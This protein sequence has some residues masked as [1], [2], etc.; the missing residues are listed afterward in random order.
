M[1]LTRD[2]DPD[3]W[4]DNYSDELYRYALSRVSDKGFAEDI[5]QDTFL[6]AW[7]S[8]ETYAENASEKNWLYAICKNKIIDH[9]RKVSGNAIHLSSAEED[10]YFDESEHWRAN[11]SPK[12]WPVDYH[13]YI[14]TKEFYTVLEGCRKKL[15]SVQQSVF[16]MKFMEEL[17]PD[18]ICATLNITSSNYWVLI[19]RC[20]LHLRSCLEKNWLNIQ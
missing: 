11:A 20:K 14:E 12:N 1:K 4:V 16:V 2:F 6:S 8:R 5:V 13:Q 7:R 18:H 17:E 15:K 3:A 10:I 19:H 9:F